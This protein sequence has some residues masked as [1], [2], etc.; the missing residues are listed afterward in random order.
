MLA[1]L[2]KKVN[3][4]RSVFEK[5]NERVKSYKS[6]VKYISSNRSEME[7]NITA[8]VETENNLYSKLYGNKSKKEVGEK[9]PQ[10]I[11]DRLS[12]ARGGWYSSSYGPTKLHMKSFDIA[13]EMFNRIKPEMDAYFENVEK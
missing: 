12:N 8:L 11:F 1:V 13:K 6:M 2:Y 10:S 3:K 9:E 5:S 7:K 4:Y